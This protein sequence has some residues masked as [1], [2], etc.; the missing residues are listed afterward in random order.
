MRITNQQQLAAAQRNIQSSRTLLAKLQEQ[1]TTGRAITRPSDDPTATGSAMR[2]HTQL[3]A[4]EQYKTNIA[5]GT[6]W[7]ATVDAALTSSEDLLRQARDLMLQGSNTGVMTPTSREAI[8]TQLDALRGDL[9]AQA[10]TTYLGRTVFAGSSDSGVAFGPG[11]P[12]PDPA[13]PAPSPYTFTGAA[14]ATVTRR[15]N[16]SESVVVDAD[17]AAAFGTGDDSVFA[18]LERTAADLR[19]G[20]DINPRVGELDQKRT[21][22]TTQHAVIG[23]RYARMERAS[24]ANLAQSTLLE[25]QRAGIEDVD[26]ASVIID[27]KSQEVAYQSALAVTAR[28]LQPTLLSYLS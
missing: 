8:A 15:I 7:L 3:R 23:T 10:N 27:L 4:V 20:G 13:A 28:A 6:A 5:D 2:V 1:A 9:L 11:T 16:D 24:D 14:G 22:L 17:G 26:P 21:A 18:L 19:A 12:D 25:T